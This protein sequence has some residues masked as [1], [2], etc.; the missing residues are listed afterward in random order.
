MKLSEAKIEDDKI[1]LKFDSRMYGIG[2]DITFENGLKLWTNQ[3]QVCDDL[4]NTA[5]SISNKLE[6]DLDHNKLNTKKHEISSR[7]KNLQ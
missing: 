5:Y 3:K 7:S 2:D 6:F 1:I 4:I